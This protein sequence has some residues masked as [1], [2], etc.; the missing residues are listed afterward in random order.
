MLVNCFIN[1]AKILFCMNKKLSLSHISRNNQ[2]LLSKLPTKSAHNVD[3]HFTGIHGWQLVNFIRLE[4]LM[5]QS[6]Y[7]SLNWPVYNC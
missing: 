7:P 5:E 6:S 3:D 2:W 1:L 4:I